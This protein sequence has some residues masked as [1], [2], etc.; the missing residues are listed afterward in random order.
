VLVDVKPSID[1][2]AMLASGQHLILTIMQ[3]V[4]VNEQAQYSTMIV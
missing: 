1:G 2:S 3:H 4:H